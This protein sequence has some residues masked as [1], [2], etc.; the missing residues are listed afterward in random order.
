[1]TTKILYVFFL[2]CSAVL[3]AV[4]NPFA[5]ILGMIGLL[6]LLGI[7]LWFI[8]EIEKSYK[9]TNKLIEETCKTIDEIEEKLK[10]IEVKK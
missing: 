6:A 8:S 5:S 4:L 3:G 7:Y 2:F 9:T 1:M 10:L